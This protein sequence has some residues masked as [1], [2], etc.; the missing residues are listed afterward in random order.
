MPSSGRLPPVKVTPLTSTKSGRPRRMSSAYPSA[1]AMLKPL[2][3]VSR[4]TVRCRRRAS[5][6]MHARNRGQ[7]SWK[8]G[9]SMALSSAALDASMDTYS[10][11]QGTRVSIWSGNW[12][13]VTRKEE[14]PSACSMPRNALICGYRIGSPTRERAQWRMVWASSRREGI[15]PGSPRISLIMALCLEMK[16]STSMR[17]S[18]VSHRQLVPTGFLWWRQQKTHLLA[19]ASDGV[20]SMH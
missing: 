13:L 9:R 7:K 10:W 3:S 1:S 12:A 14:M 19:H 18:S 17:G 4:K 11:V 6:S 16:P 5:A 2:T 8:R 20:A 15:T